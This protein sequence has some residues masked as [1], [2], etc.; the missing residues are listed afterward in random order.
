MTWNLN[1]GMPKLVDFF[2]ATQVT[3]LLQGR[4]FPLMS[5]SQ[6]VTQSNQSTYSISAITT[7]FFAS[8]A[9]R[10]SAWAMLTPKLHLCKQGSWVQTLFWSPYSCSSTINSSTAFR[11]LVSIFY[12]STSPNF[13]LP[14]SSSILASFNMNPFRSFPET[15]LLWS[16]SPFDAIYTPVIPSLYPWHFL[17]CACVGGVLSWCCLDLG[18]RWVV[19]FVAELEA[20]PDWRSLEQSF[21]PKKLGHRSFKHLEFQAG[22]YYCFPKHFPDKV[23]PFTHGSFQMLLCPTLPTAWDNLSTLFIDIQQLALQGTSPRSSPFNRTTAIPCHW[24]AHRRWRNEHL[25]DK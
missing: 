4:C 21:P 18:G 14:I 22:S 17:P 8:P 15:S 5:P 25:P 7:N 24:C 23:V 20:P 3:R 2:E 11:S 6:L 12:P 13:S 19:V 1:Y 10:L 9:I 16:G